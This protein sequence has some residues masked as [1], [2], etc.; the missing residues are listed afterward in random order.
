MLRILPWAI[1]V[2]LVISGVCHSTGRRFQQAVG[3]EEREYER[4]DE[5][6]TYGAEFGIL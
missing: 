1:M 2:T 3:F 5:K 6:K 4:L